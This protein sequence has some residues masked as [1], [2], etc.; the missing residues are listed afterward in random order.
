MGI[1]Q[2]GLNALYIIVWSWAYGGQELEAKFDGLNESGSQRL[3]YLS[4]FCTAGV[5]GS[6]CALRSK[7]PCHFSVSSVGFVLVDQM[8][9]P[10]FA[11]APGLSACCHAP[12]HDGHTIQSS[13]TIS[14]Q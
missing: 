3:M 6:G 7:R 12:C 4:A 9:A 8:G 1:S 14:S 5:T 13:G 10:S 2:V 11:P